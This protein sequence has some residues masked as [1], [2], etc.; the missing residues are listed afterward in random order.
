[1]VAGSC[2]LWEIA[3]GYRERDTVVTVSWI[4]WLQGAVY[5]GRK[6]EVIGREIP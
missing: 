4:S 2:I 1:M 6:L 3:G 5:Y